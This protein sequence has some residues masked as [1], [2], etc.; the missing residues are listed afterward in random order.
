VIIKKKKEKKKGL[1]IDILKQLIIMKINYHNFVTI[2]YI[3][4]KIG[5]KIIINYNIGISI[6]FCILSLLKKYL[7]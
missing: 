4:I 5:R 2:F 6:K 1:F 7:P 3:E